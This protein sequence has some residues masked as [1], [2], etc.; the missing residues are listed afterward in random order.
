MHRYI[1]PQWSEP[2]LGVQISDFGVWLHCSHDNASH[3]AGLESFAPLL[4]S[5]APLGLI[6]PLLPGL[7]LGLAV[8]QRAM[9]VD[10]VEQ[11]Q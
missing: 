8:I 10:R 4:F 7:Y 2:G 6:R 3:Q 1:F 9:V 5:M 11:H